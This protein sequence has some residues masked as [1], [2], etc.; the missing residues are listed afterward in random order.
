M[1]FVE[2]P[3]F[4]LIKTAYK[5]KKPVYVATNLLENMIS[6]KDPTRAEVNDVISTLEMGAKGLVLAAETAIG[7]FPDK[8]VISNSARGDMIDDHAMVEALKN[9][10]IFSLGL[11]VYNGE[12]NI[13]PEY[14]KLPNVFVLPHLGSSTMKT[15]TSMA[16]LAIKNLEEFLS[17]VDK[18]DDAL[19]LR[20]V[21]GNMATFI[22]IKK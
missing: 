17:A 11:D 8:A 10:K 18:K 12:P 2:Q 14:L 4:G 9:G 13:H 6:K 1:F 19:L 20:I 7:K 5:Q 22:V 15:R 16:D 3:I 21:R